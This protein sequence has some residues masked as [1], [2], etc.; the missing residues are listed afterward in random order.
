MPPVPGWVVVPGMAGRQ[1]RP[2]QMHIVVGSLGHASSV[3]SHPPQPAAETAMNPRATANPPR[4]KEESDAASLVKGE[5]K[6]IEILR[7]A[8][9]VISRRVPTGAHP[10]PGG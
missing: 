9:S 2:S 4:R 3:P 8:T 7:G 6:D 10:A 1:P 5:R